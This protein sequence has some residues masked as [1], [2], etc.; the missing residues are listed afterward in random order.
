MK[1]HNCLWNDVVRKDNIILAYKKAR[2][3]KGDRRCVKEF[4]LD[5]DANIKKIRLS[6]VNKTFTTSRYQEKIIYE[7]KQRT[8]YILPFDPDRIVQHALMNVLE[9]LIDS[10][11]FYHSYACRPGKGI[12]RGAQL[13]MRYVYRNK[14]CLKC[15]VSKFY[16]SVNHAVM[17][18]IIERI[19]SDRHV[20]WL[21]DDI[22]NSIDGETNLPIGNYMS[23]WLGNLY[24]DKLD[25]FVKEEF[26][27][28]DYVRYCDDFLLFGDDKHILFHQALELQSFMKEE[29]KMTLSKCSLF[30]VSHGV[31][32][33]GY[34]YFKDKIL[35]RK[36]TAKEIK[37]RVA[38]LYHMFHNNL[39]PLEHIY[40]SLQSTLGWLKWANSYN[41]KVAVDIY[42]LADEVRSLLDSEKSEASIAHGKEV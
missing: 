37:K 18:E 41:L 10:R 40:G 38:M 13:T 11:L 26:H 25:R 4:D 7:P 16:P 42:K 19:I 22:V 20:L 14:Y 30:P 6:L 12:H 5:F 27:T 35:V 2:R 33:L 8:I 1:R 3:G 23:Q 36:R 32:F 29:L 9:P 24:L 21:I 17:M 28:K 39:A 31:D 15:D 34:R